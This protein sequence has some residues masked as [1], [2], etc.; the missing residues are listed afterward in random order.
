VGASAY[1]VGN[2]IVVG[3]GFVAGSAE[4][5]RL[6]AHELVHVIQQE[7]AVPTVQGATPML[8]A[9]DPLEHEAQAMAD[10]VVAGGNTDAA[11]RAASQGVHRQPRGSGSRARSDSGTKPDSGVSD[12]GTKPDSGVSDAGTK[13]DSGV[14]DAGTKP[15]SGVSQMVGATRTFSLTF[16][17]GPHTEALGSGRNRTENVLDTLKE[18]SI[19]A[20]FFVQ[21]GVRFRMASLI[22]RA[23][24]ARMHA[25]GHKV[26]IHTGGPE[27]HELHTTAQEAGR[28][29]GELIAGKAAIKQVTGSEPTLVRP[30]ERKFNEAVEATYTKVG[31]TNLLWDIDVDQGMNKSL[32]VLKK[33]V[34]AGIADVRGRGWKTTTPSPTI[35]VLLHDIQQRTA[36]N[37]G[38]VIDH[39]KT[40][41][42]KL[43]GGK[44]STE[45]SP[46]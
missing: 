45:F 6:L 26:G 32:P 23:L 24:V 34:E 35:V 13:P 27:S 31:L 17:D 30:P 42:K 18:R 33:R 15:D 29:E 36:E 8:D 46:P 12:A 3:E 2:H 25:E 38:A 11:S 22:G 21:T 10:R 44:D 9:A 39:I 16:D 20:G 4:G 14:S 19:R 37:L 7:S 28:L 41:V 43:S 1:T 40:T 5:Q